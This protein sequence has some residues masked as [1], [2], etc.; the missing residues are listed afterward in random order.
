MS[1]GTIFCDE[2]GYTGP[3][4]LD[5]QDPY[6]SF[7]S[8]AVSPDEANKLVDRVIQKYG[9]QGGELKGSRLLKY[10]KGRRAIREIFVQLDGR[11]KVALFEKRFALACKF[12]EYIFEPVVAS[13]SLIFYALRFHFFISNLLY[14]HFTQSGRYADRIFA[15]FQEFMRNFD[16]SKLV[17]LKGKLT[18]SDAPPALELIGAFAAANFASVREEME[19]VVCSTGKWTLDLSA[20]SLHSLLGEW[21]EVYDDLE[22]TCDDSKPLAASKIVLDKMIGNDDKAY[23]TIFGE[24][25]RLTYNL[26]RPI[27]LA[28]SVDTPGVQI[29]DVIAAT[30]A[31]VFENP[32]DPEYAPF[33]EQAIAALAPNVV[34]IPMLSEVD[35]DDSAVKRNYLILLELVRRS[36]S[37]VSILPGAAEYAID[38]T[39]R[40]RLPMP[41]L[42]RAFITA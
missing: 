31:A 8:V 11:L 25:R 13:H 22:V 37:G 35:L 14:L 30:T 19:S 32:D 4:L 28:K 26:A 33:R 9:V 16:E 42:K 38:L 23:V 27:S 2:S 21:A 20:S 40:M 1:V 7:A 12:H 34:V 39:E 5:P 41:D 10:A 17:Y 15:E 6:F 18:L 3:D 24:Q 29:A 36:L